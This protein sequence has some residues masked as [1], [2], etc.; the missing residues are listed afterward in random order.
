MWVAYTIIGLLLALS[1]VMIYNLQIWSLGLKK[2]YPKKDCLSDV[3]LIKSAYNDAYDSLKRDAL[4]EYVT[5]KEYQLKGSKTKFYGPYQCFCQYVESDP[6]TNPEW[7]ANTKY[8][9]TYKD[10]NGQA[11]TVQEAIC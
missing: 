8:E 10:E 6:I 1:G 11:V 5:N 3:G 7:K 9:I 2:R 4:K